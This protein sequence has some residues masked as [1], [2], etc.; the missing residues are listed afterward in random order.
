MNNLKQIK[1][2]R[3]TS[4]FLKI[5]LFSF[6]YISSMEGMDIAQAALGA[7]ATAG[8][9]MLNQGPRNGIKGMIVSI[10]PTE[11][12]TQTIIK[13]FI[14]NPV[15]AVTKA[16]VQESSFGKLFALA[17]IAGCVGICVVERNKIALLFRTFL[18]AQMGEGQNNDT[19]TILSINREKREVNTIIEEKFTALSKTMSNRHKKEKISQKRIREIGRK[20]QH[21]DRNVTNISNAIKG[22]Y[23]GGNQVFSKIIAL[24]DNVNAL[25]NNTST[26]LQMVE[27]MHADIN[28]LDHQ[29]KT[30]F[31]AMATKLDNINNHLVAICQQSPEPKITI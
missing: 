5:I 29:V 18:A 25:N 4:L 9:G 27:E 26:I 15:S 10:S 21:T 6:V 14:Q 23:D 7:A 24:E 17:A 22:L 20:V 19:N 13:S 8:I 12:A 16:V 1:T 3:I 30:G 28:N 31:G 11:A 2:L